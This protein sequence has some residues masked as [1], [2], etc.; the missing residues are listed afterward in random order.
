M[1]C[2]LRK[3]TQ[4]N[5]FLHCKQPYTLGTYLTHIK[6]THTPTRYTDAC[7]LEEWLKWGCNIPLE[8]YAQYVQDVRSVY[9]F[10]KKILISKSKYDYQ[11]LLFWRELSEREFDHVVFIDDWFRP[12][13]LKAAIAEAYEYIVEQGWEH[14]TIDPLKTYEVKRWGITM[15]FH[16]LE[17]GEYTVEKGFLYETI[18]SVKNRMSDAFDKQYGWNDDCYYFGLHSDFETAL[19][20]VG[21]FPFSEHY[22]QWQKDDLKEYVQTEFLDK[23]EYGRSFFRYG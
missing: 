22:D 19:R 16:I 2:W 23:F 4:N 3:C 18:G 15:A 1:V 7:S 8:D 5:L 13:T 9:H 14:Y 21:E 20:E 10:H 12:C 11:T 17:I 6:L